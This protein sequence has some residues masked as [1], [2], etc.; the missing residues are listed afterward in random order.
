MRLRV[1]EHI[2]AA[3]DNGSDAGEHGAFSRP[4]GLNPWA[5]SKDAIRVHGV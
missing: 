5:G 2:M 1:N 3:M 4:Q